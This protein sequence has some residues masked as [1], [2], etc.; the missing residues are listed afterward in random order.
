MLL[1]GLT[2]GIGAGKST[3]SRA[4][5]RRGAVVVDADRI[6]REVVEPGGAAYDAVVDRF[7]AA[8]LHE[9]GTLN[10]PALA[11]V[12]FS[13][14]RALEDLN[15]L[16]HPAITR[17]IAARIADHAGE[18]RVVVLDI[19]LLDAARRDV[20]PFDA[21]VVVDVPVEVAVG[22]L[23]AQRGID[24]ADARARVAA[25]ISREERLALA[26]IVVDNSG[27]PAALEED[28]RR[29]WDRIVS[30][31]DARRGGPQPAPDA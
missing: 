25:Q 8:V 10:R 20:Y 9:D 28:L 4:L 13:D 3:V 19:P 27:T 14:P 1:I 7:G 23:V 18:D 12:V 24:E 22:R 21:V 29:L 16:T 2:G 11:S 31:K 6:A 30:L 15:R 5:A 17:V 26:D